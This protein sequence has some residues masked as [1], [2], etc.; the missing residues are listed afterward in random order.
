MEGGR[1]LD[2][3]ALVRV[4]IVLPMYIGL[5]DRGLNYRT[6]KQAAGRVGRAGAVG[7][8]IVTRYM[9]IDCYTLDPA[10]GAK[11]VDNVAKQEL[12]G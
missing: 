10:T 3:N 7:I 2:I 9:Y 11:I 6:I 8:A 4:Y 1:G 12:G 5:K